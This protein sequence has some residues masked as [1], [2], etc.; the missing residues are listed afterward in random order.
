MSNEDRKGP[1]WRVINPTH[2]KGVDAKWMSQSV[3]LYGYWVL[4]HTGI[5]GC[6]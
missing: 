3:F 1:G 4:G 2:P 6:L 5:D